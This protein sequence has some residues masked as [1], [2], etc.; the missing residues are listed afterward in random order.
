MNIADSERLAAF[1]EKQ[2]FSF[3]QDI[4]KAGVV[5]I[6]TCGVR[7]MAE[8]RVYGL[9]NTIKKN[10]PQTIIVITGCLSRRED[11]KKRLAGRAD[12]FIPTS[13]MMQL[14]KILK[15]GVLAE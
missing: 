4:K 6:N 7:Q 8:D 15:G 2:G 9:V 13:E 12:I 14:P 1:L 10:N 3:E 11:V 5:I